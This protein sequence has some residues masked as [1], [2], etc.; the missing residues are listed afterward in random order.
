MLGLSRWLL[1]LA[2]LTGLCAVVARFVQPSLLLR[3]LPSTWLEVTGVLLL[4]CIATAI[5][6][7]A[8]QVTAKQS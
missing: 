4:F 6:G 2:V 5:L 1:V 8:E 3:I 7:I